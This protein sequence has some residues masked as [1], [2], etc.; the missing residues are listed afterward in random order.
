MRRYPRMTDPTKPRSVIVTD[1]Q[2]ADLLIAWAK[3]LSPEEKAEVRSVLDAWAAK[4]VRN[5]PNW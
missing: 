1:Q 5:S 3:G 4:G 2:L